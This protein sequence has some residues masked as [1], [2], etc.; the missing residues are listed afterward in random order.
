MCSNNAEEAEYQA[1]IILVLSNKI[2][3]IGATAIILLLIDKCLRQHLSMFSGFRSH[4]QLTQVIGRGDPSPFFWQ[5]AVK[6]TMAQLSGFLRRNSSFLMYGSL[7]K[8]LNI[9][10]L[11]LRRV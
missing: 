6:V 8:T 1:R 11:P 9:Y 7:C 4:K 5:N 3:S 10:C 2:E